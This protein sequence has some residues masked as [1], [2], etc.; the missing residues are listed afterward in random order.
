MGALPTKPSRHFSGWQTQ[1][2]RFVQWLSL[3][4]V[5]AL[6]F[7]VVSTLV[8]AVLGLSPSSTNGSFLLLLAGVLGLAGTAVGIQSYLT[9]PKYHTT[10][11]TI[12]GI[13]S[14]GLLGFFVGGQLGEQQASWAFI[15]LSIGSLLVGSLARWA[16]HGTTAD[17]DADT[18]ANTN[19]KSTR[20]GLGRK[21]R[22]WSGAAIALTSGLCAYAL[23]FGLFAWVW[24]AIDTGHLWLAVF[25]S[26]PGALYLWFARRALSL[27]KHYAIAMTIR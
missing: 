18:G 22:Q 11:G 23:A 24:I 19:A 14:G 16:Y 2:I 7:H 15:G 17:T 13:A 26:L 12:S 8:F 20:I 27:G 3:G 5:A 25:L 10:A 9:L 1:A 4:V 21:M 6:H